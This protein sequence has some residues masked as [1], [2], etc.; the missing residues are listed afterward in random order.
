MKS[1]DQDVLNQAIK[2]CFK[3]TI[4]QLRTVSDQGPFLSDQGKI[5]LIKKLNSNH[6]NSSTGIIRMIT[7]CTR[8]MA[9][10]PTLAEILYAL[11]A[12]TS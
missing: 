3:E 7:P 10:G 5:P 12:T 4:K 2:E 11:P 6:K 8:P 9:R 1:K